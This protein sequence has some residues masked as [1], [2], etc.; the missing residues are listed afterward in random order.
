M[1]ARLKRQLGSSFPFNVVRDTSK[2]GA[3]LT[4][5][6]AHATRHS[7]SHHLILQDDAFLHPDFAEVLPACVELEPEAALGLWTMK[8]NSARDGRWVEGYRECG[9]LAWC[10]PSELGAPIAK[11]L[12]ACRKFARAGS[13]SFD[14]ARV[15]D[16]IGEDML[17]DL[18]LMS[19][20]VRVL[21]PC[22]MIV[23][24]GE[25]GK[26]HKSLYGH[27]YAPWYRNVGFLKGSGSEVDWVAGAAN[28]MR[29]KT[30]QFEDIKACLPT[31]LLEQLP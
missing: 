19:A 10:F 20:G 15:G 3:L 2:S 30:D 26:K 18:W 4:T 6:R 28:P 13:L 14:D 17:R 22:P 9:G 23:A 5:I 8:E 1:V 24:H 29:Y 11:W 16:L 12:T 27:D 7:A 31:V 25:P 21:C